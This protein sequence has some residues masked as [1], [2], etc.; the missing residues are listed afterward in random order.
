MRARA[1]HN[2]VTKEQKADMAKARPAKDS[3]APESNS[4]NANE[5]EKTVEVDSSPVKK[6]DSLSHF[7]PWQVLREATQAVPA[8]KYA[9][10]VAG[11]MSVGAVIKASGFNLWSA[12]VWAIVVLVLM[13]ALL[14]FARATKSTRKEL[15]IQALVLTWSFLV[16]TILSAFF[17]FTGVFFRYPPS[18]WELLR[19]ETRGSSF[20][21]SQPCYDVRIADAQFTDYI[22]HQRKFFI[23][24]SDQVPNADATLVATLKDGSRRFFYLRS[25][26]DLYPGPGDS[27]RYGKHPAPAPGEPIKQLE[28]YLPDTEVKTGRSLI[29]SIAR[30]EAKLYSYTHPPKGYSV[31][32][33]HKVRLALN[34][35]YQCKITAVENRERPSA[36]THCHL[37]LDKQIPN[38]RGEAIVQLDGGQTVTF[39]TLPVES[40]DTAKFQG[41]NVVN[42]PATTNRFL[43][44]YSESDAPFDDLKDLV[45]KECS[46]TVFEFPPRPP[47][48]LP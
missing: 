12:F 21:P 14:L 28:I 30:G 8:V 6:G 46:V 3:R 17:L 29:S 37:V 27:N 32:S 20:S 35:T 45:R 16:L 7:F 2:S 24:F 25:L 9:V 23:F 19:P 41:F 4:S 43:V 48:E 33:M 15:R 31:A 38:A 34:D 22:E 36:W 5:N 42:S 47:N 11:I 10:G 13:V 44:Q 39:D 26:D 40:Y 18:V 1:L